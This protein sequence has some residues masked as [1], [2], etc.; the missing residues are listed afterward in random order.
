MPSGTFLLSLLVNGSLGRLVSHPTEGP[1]SSDPQNHQAKKGA[2]KK[3]RSVFGSVFLRFLVQVQL[4]A[5]LFWSTPLSISM[6]FCCG[7][8]TRRSP[9]CCVGRCYRFHRP[10]N[11]GTTSGFS[12]HYSVGLHGVRG[13]GVLLE[14][15]RSP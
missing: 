13:A 10:L 7:F 2:T 8:C 9:S 3:T 5:Q 1:S 15:R 14:I 12:K 6:V 11:I 4:K